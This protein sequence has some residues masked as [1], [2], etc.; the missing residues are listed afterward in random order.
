[1]KRI[2]VPALLLCLYACTPDPKLLEGPWHV[3]G[4]Y[5]DGQNVAAPLD[6]VRLVFHANKTYEFH[7]IGFYHES[8]TYRTSGSYL[9]LMDSTA[10]EPK[11]RALKILFLS[12]DSLK[13]AMQRD[14]VEQVLF[15]AKKQASN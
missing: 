6:S 8:G 3:T 11:E 10:K 13:I 7:S 15:L 12:N 2:F 4:Y 9:F 1:M 14:S 5:Q